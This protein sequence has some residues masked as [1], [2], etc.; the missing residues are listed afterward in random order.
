MPN[1]SRKKKPTKKPTAKKAALKK[2]VA[3]KKKSLAKK[4]AKAKTKVKTKVKAQVK[5]K[6]QQAKNWLQSPLP[7]LANQDLTAA[8]ILKRV[9]DALAPTKLS[10]QNL[11]QGHKKH[12]EAKAHGGGHY[13]ISI[14]SEVFSGLNLKQRQEWVNGLLSDLY[15]KSIHALQM[16]LKSPSEDPLKK[17]ISVP[18]KAPKPGDSQS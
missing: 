8:E 9:R 18:F 10:L 7:A 15:S 3:T 16:D 5:E 4:V 1:Q 12:K 6:I 17:D 14:I 2:A 11:T 13:S